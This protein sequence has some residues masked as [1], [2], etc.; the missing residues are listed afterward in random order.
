MTESGGASAPGEHARPGASR[1][2]Y[3]GMVTRYIVELDR[4]GELQVVQQ[5]LETSSTEA[6]DAKGTAVV[7][8]WS[9][10]HTLEI[11]TEWG[12]KEGER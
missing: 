2:V 11:D 1:L 3:A 12:E 10:E 6:L 8:E 4:G 5:N 9:P 7:L